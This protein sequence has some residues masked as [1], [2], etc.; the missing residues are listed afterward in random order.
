MTDTCFGW[1]G[2]SFIFIDEIVFKFF[3]GMVIFYGSSGSGKTETLVGGG[4]NNKN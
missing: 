2:L 4:A 3:I 1:N